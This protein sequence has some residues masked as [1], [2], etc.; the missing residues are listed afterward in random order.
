MSDCCSELKAEV[1]A[2][3]QELARIKGEI[4]GIEPRV[5]KQANAAIAAEVDP[6]WVAIAAIYGALGAIRAG[7][8]TLQGALGAIRGLFMGLIAGVRA[9]AVAAQAAA[10]SAAATAAAAAAGLAGVVARIAGLAA[11]VAGLAAGL[12]AMQ[13]AITGL[14]ALYSRVDALGAEISRVYSAV[15]S[16][17][18]GLRGEVATAK[19][20]AN[21]AYQTATAANSAANSAGSKADRATATAQAAQNTANSAANTANFALD[22][23]IGAEGT[24]TDAKSIAEQLG[25]VASNALARA[26]AAAA[27]AAQAL[28]RVNRH[29]HAVTEPKVI[30]NYYPQT[31]VYQPTREIIR[32]NIRTKEI[33]REVQTVR[34]VVQTHTREVVRTNTIQTRVETEVREV[35][36]NFAPFAQQL[37]AANSI[38]Q[39]A[40]T[41]AAGARDAATGARTA[42]TGAQSA[43]TTA[44]TAIGNLQNNFNDFKQKMVGA[45]NLSEWLA[46]LNLFV[47]LHNAAMLSRNLV[48]TLS[49]VISNGLAIVG[50]KDLDGNPV[51]FESV[52]GQTANDFMKTVLGAE[53]WLNVQTTWKA[54]STVY[55]SAANM[56]WSVV[57]IADSAR[58]VAEWTGE[59]VAKIG[60]ALRRNGVVEE[61]AYP[62]MSEQPAAFAGT[63]ARID[64]LIEG[65]DNL[66][67]A[68]GSLAMVTGEIRSAQME[69]TQL[70]E[71]RRNFRDSVTDLQDGIKASEASI[72]QLAIL[73]AD[74]T[75]EDLQPED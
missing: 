10:L 48:S 39:T 4:H 41:N 22:T 56:A 62:P 57:S 2:L 51:D 28:D 52:L 53:V 26:Q 67:N 3:R 17:I 29:G 31:T 58:N 19:N 63:Q 16:A 30:N 8:F 1:A 32:E 66:D 45:F 55:S 9:I 37:A 54:A 49:Q 61:D 11:Q 64:R 74:P 12:M 75:D 20:T 42:A 60:N 68:A 36:I 14:N 35:P 69:L 13:L 65:I 24:A 40:A 34:E 23:A 33:I 59:N 50:I 21:Q 25:A 47:S 70:L 44:A 38:A 72:K 7:L 18:G 27:Q 43:A 6:L 5:I 46:A 15:T 71:E 73:G